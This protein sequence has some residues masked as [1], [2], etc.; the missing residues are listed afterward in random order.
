M[1]LVME[2]LHIIL[3]T[4]CFSVFFLLASYFYSLTHPPKSVFQKPTNHIEIRSWKIK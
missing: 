3:S 4:L 2:N 1:N